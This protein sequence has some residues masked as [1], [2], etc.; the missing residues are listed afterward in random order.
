M[1]DI[2]YEDREKRE[3]IIILE[4]TGIYK[5]IDSGAIYGDMIPYE[6]LIDFFEQGKKE[7]QENFKKFKSDHIGVVLTG[8]NDNEPI[9]EYYVGRIETDEEFN[10][11]I[12]YLDNKPKI[13]KENDIKKLKELA[14]KYNYE[15]REKNIEK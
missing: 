13:K 5:R 1:Q 10:K 3:K 2:Y 6:K 12:E 9:I 8:L 4:F 7:A 11:R 15:L 14:E